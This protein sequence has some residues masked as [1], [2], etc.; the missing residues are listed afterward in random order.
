MS[1]ATCRTLAYLD[2]ALFIREARRHGL[3]RVSKNSFHNKPIEHMLEGLI[4]DAS[5]LRFGAGD[6]AYLSSA[7]NLV[8][9]S[10][11]V[12]SVRRQLL[13]E[14]SKR[15]PVAIKSLL[16]CVDRAFRPAVD[17]PPTDDERMAAV[18]GHPD[19]FHREEKASSFST[20]V[21]LMREVVGLPEHVHGMVDEVGVLDGTY[22]QLLWAG[23]KLTKFLEAE[24]TIDAFPYNF[25]LSNDG[26]RGTIVP[27]EDRFEKSVRLGYIQT[28]AQQF[29]LRDAIGEPPEYPSLERL[30]LDLFSEGA[31][32]FVT[33]TDDFL[34]R[35][36]MMLPLAPPV[37][38]LL[39]SDSMFRED[40]YIAEYATREAFLQNDS[41]LALGVAE[42]LTV[43][44]VIR[45]RR[46]ISFLTTIFFAGIDQPAYGYDRNV[47]DMRSRII[48]FEQNDL[49]MKLS[50]AMGPEKAERVLA[51]FSSDV[52]KKGQID[53][54]YRPLIKAQGHYMMPPGV[55]IMSDLIRG[56]LDTSSMKLAP[57]DGHEPMLRLLKQALIRQGFLAEEGVEA[58][59]GGRKL[60]LDLVAFKDGHLFVFEGKNAFHPCSPQ[61]MRNTYDHV[62][63]AADQLQRSAAWLATENGRA[64]LFAKLRWPS[65]QVQVVRTCTVTANRILNG[66]ELAGHPIRQARELLNVLLTG[67]AHFN[68]GESFSTWSG[69]DFTV[70]DLCNHLDASSYINE[71][72]ESM[73]AFEPAI[74][75]GSGA[76]ATRTFMLDYEELLERC[77]SRYRSLGSNNLHRPPQGSGA[78]STDSSA[79]APLF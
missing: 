71:S 50:E 4:S 22:D 47:L 21:S 29:I 32:T 64:E 41:V 65:E 6:I 67:E 44:D 27:I 12:A 30:S 1:M 55:L 68:T 51:V 31:R 70:Q 42:G 45:F 28:Q 19:F 74:D 9:F 35:Y 25:E 11:H 52:E 13:L 7:K 17:A 15:R 62:R 37:V 53:I 49:L 69:P 36:R 57:A 20:I 58:E 18:I 46:F 33:L 48:V 75:I 2:S 10:T 66:H 43:L 39:T 3:F 77:R 38:A 59:F 16:V 8:E 26:K 73:R 79:G 60:E 72:F 63:K 23:H 40:V 5:L 61:E 76:L 54:Q 34:P 14:L 24:T 56:A 78:P